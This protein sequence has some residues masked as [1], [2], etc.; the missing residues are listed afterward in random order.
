MINGFLVL[1]A[2]GSIVNIP[3]TSETVDVYGSYSRK[4]ANFQASLSLSCP[5][6]STGSSSIR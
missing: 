3:N 4:G 5:Y 6:A 1:A 2:N